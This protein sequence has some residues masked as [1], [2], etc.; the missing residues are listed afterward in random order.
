M[1]NNI[2]LII[3]FFAFNLIVSQDLKLPAI[4][5]DNMILQQDSVVSIWGWSKSNSQ[6]SIN[7]SWNKKTFKIKSNSEGKWLLKVNTPK[8][9]KSHQITVQSNNKRVIIANE[10]SIFLSSTSPN[11]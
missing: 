8:S 6:V 4:F 10:D 11:P 5:S 3:S 2:V 1:K 9:G 7:V